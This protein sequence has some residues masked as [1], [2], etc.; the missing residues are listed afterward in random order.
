MKTLNE[1]SDNSA[2]FDESTKNKENSTKSSFQNVV[3]LI[4]THKTTNFTGEKTHFSKR[5]NITNLENKNQNSVFFQLF[6][7]KICEKSRMPRKF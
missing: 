6:S 7:R 5:E 4:K 2:K 3:N 1:R